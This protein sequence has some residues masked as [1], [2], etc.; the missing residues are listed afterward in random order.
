MQITS[1]GQ[2]TKHNLQSDLAV[3]KS[4]DMNDKDPCP[5]EYCS[6][7]KVKMKKMLYILF[8]RNSNGIHCP[9]CV[10]NIVLQ[11]TP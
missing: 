3:Q 10:Q 11:F 5:Y 4:K 2:N 8:C 6:I 9:D 1:R 7:R